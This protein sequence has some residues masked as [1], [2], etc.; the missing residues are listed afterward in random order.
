M[1]MLSIYLGMDVNEKSEFPFMTDGMSKLLNSTGLILAIICTLNTIVAVYF[2]RI[3]KPNDKLVVSFREHMK[4][5]EQ[6]L[7]D[8]SL[9]CLLVIVGMHAKIHP[10]NESTDT[11]RTILLGFI[12]V[13]RLTKVI[14]LYIFNTDTD[15]LKRYEFIG[16]KFPEKQVNKV[17]W[18]QN[19]LALGL[20]TYALINEL[21]VNSDIDVHLLLIIL[22]MVVQLGLSFI[23]GCSEMGPDGPV[24]G[25]ITTILHTLTM[26]SLLYMLD[27]H[28][29][30]SVVAVM[31]GD[32]VSRI[33]IGYQNSVIK[34]TTPLVGLRW[35]NGVSVVLSVLCILF[36]YSI[37][38]R[39]ESVETSGAN[40]PILSS[41]LTTGDIFI[42]FTKVLSIIKTGSGLLCFIPKLFMEADDVQDDEIYRTVSNRLSTVLLFIS[43]YLLMDSNKYKEPGY[44]YALF[45]VVILHR[46]CDMFYNN[47]VITGKKTVDIEKEGG[48]VGRPAV[49]IFPSWS[50]LQSSLGKEVGEVGR[51]A[52]DNFRSWLVV[53][54]LLVSFG[55]AIDWTGPAKGFHSKWYFWVYCILIAVHIVVVVVAFVFSTIEKL[56]NRRFWALSTM[57]LVRLA[58]ASL[59]II[60][61][62]TGM[63]GTPDVQTVVSFVAYMFADAVG[64]NHM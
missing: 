28:R 31:V 23:K 16:S 46:I 24:V 59:V 56:G 13:T 47:L 17:N 37:G 29:V 58:V 35:I 40:S 55:T 26:F 4:N 18:M 19:V 62:G 38:D 50:G 63:V 34:E 51:P 20:F 53:A 14:D 3:A 42:I 52:V 10:I 22:S 36:A 7:R 8:L 32:I 57:E 64:R 27:E 48:E 30:V 54:L 11:F 21:V 49:D 15:T 41:D 25:G 60:I 12:V 2:D 43:S 6:T 39:T 9:I 44:I 1:A 5:V 45:I 33:G 61:A